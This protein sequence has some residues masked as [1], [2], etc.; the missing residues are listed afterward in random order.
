MPGATVPRHFWRGTVVPGILPGTKWRGLE[1]TPFLAKPTH[2]KNGVGWRWPKESQ[3]CTGI[4]LGCRF[5]TESE[6]GPGWCA[7]GFVF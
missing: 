3:R 7:S 4:E 2:A 6:P 5:Q 1:P